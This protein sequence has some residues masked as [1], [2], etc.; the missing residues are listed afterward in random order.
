MP[1]YYTGFGRSSQR[2]EH[3]PVFTKLLKTGGTRIISDKNIDLFLRQVQRLSQLC[4]TRSHHPLDPS[5]PHP[6]PSSIA[7][8]PGTLKGLPSS[9]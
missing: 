5:Q 6:K 7:G 1:L 8:L 9:L 3:P 4:Q 2:K